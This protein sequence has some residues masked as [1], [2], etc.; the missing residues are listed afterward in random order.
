VPNLFP[1]VSG[2]LGRQEVVVH[3]PRHAR[4]LAELSPAECERV[5]TAWRGRA[6][7]A[8]AAGF[9]YVH[10]FVNEGREA[11][12]S[13]CH[14]HSQLAWLPEPP[15]ETLAERERPGEPCR[16]CRLL[17]D[18]RSAGI[19]IVGERDGLVLVS[20]YAARAPYELLVAPADCE[21]DGLASERL[22][23]G[24]ALLAAAVAALRGLEERAPLNAWL[25]TSPLNERR[26]HWHLELLPRLTVPAGLELGA[27]IHVNLLPPEE[28]AAALRARL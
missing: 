17:A 14:S 23:A 7:E 15:P 11:G 27:G 18:E 20:P 6:E 16:L 1:A 3:T 26:G 21:A 19:R 12:A 5:A 4:S 24:L 10:A 28:A 22:G 2:P 25:H 13:L 8:R 9:H